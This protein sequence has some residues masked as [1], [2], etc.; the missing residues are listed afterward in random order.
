MC[1][2][3]ITRVQNFATKL[4]YFLFVFSMVVPFQ[5]LMFTLS[6]LSDRLGFN[7]P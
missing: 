1:A 3:F 7:T 2:W 6:G 4:V 5:M